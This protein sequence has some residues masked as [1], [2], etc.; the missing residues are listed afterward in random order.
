MTLESCAAFCSLQTADAAHKENHMADIMDKVVNESLERYI[1]ERISAFLTEE[2]K[3]GKDA[4]GVVK[5]FLRRIRHSAFLKFVQDNFG[6]HVAG[7]G[8]AGVGTI[9]AEKIRAINWDG[10]LPDDQRD[11]TRTVRMVLKEAIPGVIAGLFNGAADVLDDDLVG[12]E[13]D[14]LIS[15]K[16]GA[17]AVFQQSPGAFDKAFR[18]SP[19][20]NIDTLKEYGPLFPEL[21]A[22]GEVQYDLLGAIKLAGSNGQRFSRDWYAK[23]GESYQ[24]VVEQ[25]QDNGQNRN[26]NGRGGNQN[27]TPRTR[28]VLVPAKPY[29]GDLVP[30]EAE[31][32]LMAANAPL[33]ADI[34]DLI[35]TRLT[36]KPAEPKKEE[37][38]DELGRAFQFN[39]AETMAKLQPHEQRKGQDLLSDIAADA[40]KINLLGKTFQLLSGQSVFTAAQ[41]ASVYEYVQTWQG[42][43]LTFQTEVL[44]ALR[45]AK[46]LLRSASSVM[47]DDAPPF[48]KRLEQA[49]GKVAYAAGEY[50][51]KMAVFTVS[52][53]VMFLSF[54]LIS[55]FYPNLKAPMVLTVWDSMYLLPVVVYGLI[56]VWFRGWLGFL[57]GT[58]AA[59]SLVPAIVF[60]VANAVGCTQVV[61]LLAMIMVS[62]GFTACLMLY[63]LTPAQL[64]LSFVTQFIPTLDKDWLVNKGRIIMMFIATHVA[65]MTIMVAFKTPLHLRFIIPVITLFALAVQMGLAGYGFPNAARNRAYKTMQM[66][67]RLSTATT[68]ALVVLVVLSLFGK[69]PDDIKESVSANLFYQSIV[70]LVV[71]GFV[72]SLIVQWMEWTPQGN[73]AV[74]VPKVNPWIR[75]VAGLIV[76]VCVL[77][78]WIGPSVEAWHKAPPKASAEVIRVER[79]DSVQNGK[80]SAERTLMAKPS[81]PSVR[82]E[83]RPNT[84]LSLDCSRL[85]PRSRAQ[86]GCK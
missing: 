11:L 10:I 13:I 8:M 40:K 66:L 61:E 31:L 73:P 41:V 3:N 48:A 78:P 50:A 72:V 18:L 17:S 68:I 23:N 2:L 86:Y 21:D 20:H 33:P 54:V 26:N 30:I 58:F 47:A 42:S 80:E 9:I 46:E 36:P 74:L 34:Q 38:V 4:N 6:A 70:I 37:G 44:H 71:C 67:G 84:G 14:R 85:S 1:H 35:R 81:K 65:I 51:S 76:L 62:C 59:L 24:D 63:F 64:V 75:S 12:K 49:I 28:R 19:Q 53:F 57:F 55:A 32:K 43:K 22:K 7:L 15:V 29:T 16:T 52:L 77:W 83:A 5:G 27:H 56:A 60:I 39:W 79:D 45:E 82:E 25:A 69:S